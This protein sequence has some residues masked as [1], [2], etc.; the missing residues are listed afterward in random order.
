[1]LSLIAVHP[2]HLARGVFALSLGDRRAATSPRA[3]TGG[4][5]AESRECA[6]LDAAERLDRQ[7]SFLAWAAQGVQLAWCDSKAGKHSLPTISQVFPFNR[8][9][10]RYFQ[11]N[12]RSRCSPSQG[13]RRGDVM[14]AVLS[15]RGSCRRCVALQ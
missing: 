11:A 7:R 15:A 8:E 5:G 13:E 4:C 9:R 2:A 3:L 12:T 10:T 1:M 14:S 6:A